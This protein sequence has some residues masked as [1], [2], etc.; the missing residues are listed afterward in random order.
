VSNT[1]QYIVVAAQYDPIY[2]CFSE[3]SVQAFGGDSCPFLAPPGPGQLAICD[4]PPSADYIC[5]N[6]KWIILND[7]RP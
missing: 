7:Y 5:K 3:G 6:G 2:A 1:L 4:P